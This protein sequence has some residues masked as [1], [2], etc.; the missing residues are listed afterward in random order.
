MRVVK[1]VWREQIACEDSIGHC[2]LEGNNWDILHCNN[3]NN[4]TE[5]D[6]KTNTTIATDIVLTLC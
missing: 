3:T 6:I 5:N 4:H 1:G 2:S